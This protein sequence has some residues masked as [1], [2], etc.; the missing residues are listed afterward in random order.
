LAALAG[1]VERPRSSGNRR[2]N[3]GKTR[4]KVRGNGRRRELSLSAS[5]VNW[6]IERFASDGQ[7]PRV[8]LS[9]NCSKN[10]S[11]DTRCRL[12]SNALSSLHLWRFGRPRQ[13][14][15]RPARGAIETLFGYARSRAA[16]SRLWIFPHAKTFRLHLT[17]PRVSAIPPSSP[18][19]PR[20]IAPTVSTL[21]AQPADPSKPTIP[22]CHAANATQT[23]PPLPQTIDVVGK[24]CLLP[25]RQGMAPP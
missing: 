17:T 4:G 25:A 21:H 2:P 10:V 19:T 14:S 3:A 8:R 18:I 9:S 24:C 23:L 13:K 6:W 1:E 16:L 11:R 22:T 5:R 20:G 7:A 15:S 12:F